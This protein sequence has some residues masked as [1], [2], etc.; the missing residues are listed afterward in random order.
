MAVKTDRTNTVYCLKD[1]RTNE[2]RYVGTTSLSLQ[3][4]LNNHIGDTASAK[5]VCKK[6][7]DVLRDFGFSPKVVW[8]MELHKLGLSPRIER[9]DTVEGNR[10]RIVEEAWLQLFKYCGCHL[11]NSTGGWDVSRNRDYTKYGL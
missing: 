8:I 11:V 4:R 6:F 10:A 2:V 9:L 7:G 3:S 1:P 5:Q